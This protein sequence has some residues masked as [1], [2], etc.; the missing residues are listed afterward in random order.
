MLDPARSSPTGLLTLTRY[1]WETVYTNDEYDSC[2]TAGL[3]D[4]RGYCKDFDSAC[5]S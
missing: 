2:P 4:Y 3:G 5:K 1:Q